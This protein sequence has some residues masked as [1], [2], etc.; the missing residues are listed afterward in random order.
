MH[1]AA[2][3]KVM[4]GP[5]IDAHRGECGVPGL[6][7][8]DRY[9]RAI[10][11]GV[12]FVEIDIRRI[13]DGTFV[14]YHDDLTPSGHDVRDLSY[15][16]LKAELGPELVRVDELVDIIDGRVGLHVD[17]KEEGYEAEVVRTIQRSFT[18]SEV[19]YTS[20][21][22]PIR[23]IKDQ[24]PTLRT[25]LS[26][27]DDLQGVSPWLKIGVRL[28]ELF[29]S[30]RLRRSHADF[31]AVHKDLARVRVLA[32]CANAHIPAWV[33]TVDDEEEIA[34]FMRDPRVAVLITNRPDLAM[35]L[36]TA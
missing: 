8:D 24:F 15:S 29:P 1:Q 22:D 13:A 28:S 12:D 5:L 18:R 27:G 26:L 7:A 3:G 2:G 33:W 6:P 10:A 17:V 34:K 14:N 11:L 23:V 32:Y 21:D 36:T 16:E 31:L 19:V 35:K 25:G 4:T 9:V 30:T 20:G